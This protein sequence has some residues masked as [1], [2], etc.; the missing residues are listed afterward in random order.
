VSRAFAG[1][2]GRLRLYGA[3]AIA[4]CL[5]FGALSFL[6]VRHLDQALDAEREHAAQL[7]RIQTIRTSIV[8]ADANAT[9]AFLVGGLPGPEVTTGYNEGIAT[10][11]ATITEASAADP[12]DA[13]T[14]ESVNRALAT[15]TGTV[16][17][18]RANNR[19]GFPIGAAYMRQASKSLQD[20]ALPP[21]AQLVTKERAR[22]DSSAS[23]A[24]DTERNL[25]ILTLVVLIALLVV[26][27][28][29]YARTHRIVNRPLALATVLVVVGSL[30][31]LAVIQ[32][33]RTTEHDARRGSYAQ[34]VALAT[35]RIDAFDAKS[36][37]SLTLILRGSGQAYEDHFKAL[38]ANARSASRESLG[39]GG[40]GT[41]S[42]FEAYV[43]QHAQVRKL[44]DN[45]DHDA[46]VKLAISKGAANQ[47]FNAFEAKS[48]AALDERAGQLS[49][50]L[51]HARLPALILA[52]L[53]LAVGLI[54]A[55][56]ARR[57]IAQRLREYR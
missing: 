14:L 21:L 23:A 17:S 44:D 16:E 11:A 6:F 25:L 27:I 7:V 22:V 51:D 30:L 31:G 24:A 35:V 19:Q 46:A 37:E 55:V 26:Q 32:W 8:K 48:G 54:A 43:R 10:A 9:N 20:S 28:W 41:V 33:S 52:W 53:L 38:V 49:D 1:T 5:L 42:A 50:D 3:I 40:A 34:T 13:K 36:A 15:Y 57:G 47:A 45:G 4:A 18:A 56:A 12:Q 29:L 39:N 2:P